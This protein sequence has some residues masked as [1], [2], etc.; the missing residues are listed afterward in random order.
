MSIA[1]KLSWE[2]VAQN[3]LEPSQESRTALE[4]AY[5]VSLALSD[6]ASFSSIMASIAEQVTDPET[7]C[8][9]KFYTARGLKM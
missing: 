4:I 5:G 3:E 2:I 1:Q 8:N 7:R 9:L 6:P